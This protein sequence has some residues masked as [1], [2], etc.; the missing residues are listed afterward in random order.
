MAVFNHTLVAGT[1]DWVN[2]P[3]VPAQVWVCTYNVSTGN[4]DWAKQLDFKSINTNVTAITSLL[5]VG[6]N[7]YVGTTGANNTGASIYC[8]FNAWS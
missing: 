4:C 3:F 2:N 1:N 5:V 8:Y 6:T 7:L